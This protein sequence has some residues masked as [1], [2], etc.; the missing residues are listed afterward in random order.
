MTRIV[1]H[2]E[3]GGDVERPRCGDDL[4]VGGL[5]DEDH[6]DVAHVV[7]LAGARL[8]HADDREPR[9][10]DLGGRERAGLGRLAVGSTDD[11][12]GGRRAPRRARRRRGRRALRRPRRRRRPRRLGSRSYT[13]DAGEEPPVAH[14]DAR[15]RGLAASRARATSLVERRAAARRVP[16]RAERRR[17][18][19]AAKH[20]SSAGCRSRK[21]RESRATRRAAA[22]SA[23]PTRRASSTRGDLGRRPLVQALRGRRAPRRDRPRARTPRA[24]DRRRPRSRRRAP[25]A[26]PRRRSRSSKPARASRAEGRG[27]PGHPVRVRGSRGCAAART[28]SPASGSR[29]TRRACW[30]ARS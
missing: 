7:E 10:G 1:D 22:P 4:F 19:P 15:C 21:S 26:P 6:V 16:R 2:R 18:A 9:R 23:L 3:A 8:A 24:A 20:A 5:R 17:P 25:R 29:A 12:T 30:R 11:A 14:P 27:L 28:A 13:R